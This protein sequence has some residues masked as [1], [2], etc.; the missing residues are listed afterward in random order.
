MSPYA[1]P[2]IKANE[3]LGKRIKTALNSLG[4]PLQG[5]FAPTNVAFGIRDL[6]KQPSWRNSKVFYRFDGRHFFV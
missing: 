4:M 5:R 2:C 6:D 3:S 1:I